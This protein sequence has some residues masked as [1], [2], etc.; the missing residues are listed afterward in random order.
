MNVIGVIFALFALVAVAVIAYRA[1]YLRG[2]AELL[3]QGQ[4]TEG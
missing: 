2:Q 4:P 1:G 3:C